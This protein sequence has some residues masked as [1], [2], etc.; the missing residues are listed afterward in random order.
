VLV[1]RALI[2]AH[3]IERD[4]AKY[5]RLI[6]TDDAAP[7]VVEPRFSLNDT[8][9][10]S[11][12]RTDFDGLKFID[13]LRGYTRDLEEIRAIRA[14][15]AA[16]VARTYDGTLKAVDALNLRSKYEWTKRY[17]D[18]ILQE[19]VDTQKAAP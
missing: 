11:L 2:E 5:P 16:D 12:V 7:F 3:K 10:G 19:M 13:I 1:G 6:V 8:P 4:V 17:L 15:V 18:Q 9:G 14:R